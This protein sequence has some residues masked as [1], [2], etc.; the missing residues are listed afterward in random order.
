MLASLWNAP[1]SM[2]KNAGLYVGLWILVGVQALIAVGGAGPLA[3]WGDG[4]FLLN[5]TA[6]LDLPVFILGALVFG[7]STAIGIMGYAWVARQLEKKTLPPLSHLFT[8]ALGLSLLLTIVGGAILL[9]ARILFSFMGGEGVVSILA[10]I[11]ALFAALILG[12]AAIKLSFSPVLLGYGLSAK[13]AL[14]ESWRQTT[15]H[16]W[17]LLVLL[18]LMSVVTGIIQSLD[19]FLPVIENEIITLLIVVTL[20]AAALFYTGSVLALALPERGNLSSFT[21]RKHMHKR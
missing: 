6:P 11:V 9:L 5:P 20:G 21:P 13:D 15:G 1:F 4:G 7:I 14:A 19:L 17:G 16:F 2:I 3:E 10:M 8:Q 18:I 12:F